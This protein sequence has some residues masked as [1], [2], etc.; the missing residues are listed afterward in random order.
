MERYIVE[1]AL[2]TT[3]NFNQTLSTGLYQVELIS[4]SYRNTLRMSVVR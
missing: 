3:L 4:G 2:N 1:G